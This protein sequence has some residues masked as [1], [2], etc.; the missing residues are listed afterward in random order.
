M[1]RNSCESYSNARTK[2]RR[3]NKTPKD[4]LACAV[5][6]IKPEALIGSLSKTEFIQFR[7]SKAEKQSVKDTAASLDLTVSEY[8]L[9]VHSL[10]LTRLKVK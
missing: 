9:K 8:L 1:E 10:I 5:A 2:D 6:N 4:N 7:I 3:M